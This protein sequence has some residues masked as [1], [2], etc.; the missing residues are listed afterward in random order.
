MYAIDKKCP[1]MIKKWSGMERGRTAYASSWVCDDDCGGGGGG[2]GG[3]YGVGD[4]YGGGDDEAGWAL[5]LVMCVGRSFQ[6]CRNNLMTAL[7]CNHC[8]AIT[9]VKSLQ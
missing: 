4:D 2:N 8:S 9:A 3:D 5:G 6:T 7:P 1:T